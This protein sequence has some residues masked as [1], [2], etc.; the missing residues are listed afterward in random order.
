MADG[1]AGHDAEA[2][3]EAAPRDVARPWVGKLGCVA[4]GVVGAALGWHLGG[5][6]RFALWPGDG[7][8]SWSG[9]AY[10]ALVIGGAVVIAWLGLDSISDRNRRAIRARLWSGWGLA[11]LAAAVLPFCSGFA[12]MGGELLFPE[13]REAFERLLADPPDRASIG[14]WRSIEVRDAPSGGVYF[15]VGSRSAMIDRISF[16]FAHR[17][18]PIRSPFGGKDYRLV[19][20][21]GEWYRFVANNDY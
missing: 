1:V 9:L 21:E 20:I 13:H 5:E 11:A 19:H 12:V 4:L 3:V 10:V 18:D 7:L 2:G 17:P 6:A 8:E 14:P 15:A 16:G